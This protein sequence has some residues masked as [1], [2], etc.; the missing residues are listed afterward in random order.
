MISISD[1]FFV[2]LMILVFDFRAKKQKLK[3]DLNL[4]IE[5]NKGKDLED[6]FLKMLK[7]L[8]RVGEAESKAIAQRFPT[9]NH[10]FSAWDSLVGRNDLVG[11]ED[12]LVGCKVCFVFFFVGLRS[13]EFGIDLVFFWC[14]GGE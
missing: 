13:L 1:D 8:P 9:L 2:C 5:G 12:M 4:E 7:C 11:A 3:S 6:T 10:L 14:G